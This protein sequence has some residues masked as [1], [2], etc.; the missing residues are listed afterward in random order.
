MP[1]VSKEIPELREKQIEQLSFYISHPKCIDLSDPGTGKT[2]PVCVYAYFMWNRWENKTLWTMP[3]SLLKKNKLE[4]E[5]F[6]AFEDKDVV[7]MKNDRANLTKDWTGPTLASSRTQRGYKVRL[8]GASQLT[9]TVELRDLAGKPTTF[10]YLDLTPAKYGPPSPTWIL[11][12]SSLKRLTEYTPHSPGIIVEPLRGPDGQ[13]QKMKRDKPEV[14]KDLIQAAAD[15]GAKV[16]ICT[17][18]FATAHYER[19]FEANPEIDLFLIDEIHMPGGYSTPNTKATD[20]FFMINRKVSRMVAMTGTLINGRLDSAFPVIHA[21]EPRYYGS[22]SGFLFE[23]AAVTDDYGRVVVWKNENKITKIL[24]RHGIKRT[25]EEVYGKEPVVFFTEYVDI[26]DD[27]RPSYDQFHEQA[28]LELEDGRVLDGSLPG[29]ALIRARQLLAHPETMLK[30]ETEWT[31]RDER[32]R[33]HLLEGK[34]TLIF[35]ALKPEQN[36]LL[37]LA[38]SMGLRAELINSDVSGAKRAQIDQLAQE[39]KLDVIVG[40]GPTVAVG[41]NWEMFDLVIFASIDY[42]DTNILQAYR[43]ASRGTR[44]SIL[45]VIFIRYADSVDDRSYDIVRAKSQ[46]AN[47]VDDTRPVLEFTEQVEKK[48]EPMIPSLKG[49]MK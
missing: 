9:D 16:F 17:F 48:S 26:A 14:F 7:I 45:R 5:R 39:G 40:S 3:K 22:L 29:V 20:S 6:T 28:L 47:R 38:R 25:F 23:H 27:V 2:P 10:C 41:Y 31:P 36:R 32:I 4:M 30:S 21:I 11:L 46:L 8:P 43:R 42:M 35:A 34:K 18:A 19:L 49:M 13:P 1:V 15:D 37:A 24:E 33:I 44:T 12:G